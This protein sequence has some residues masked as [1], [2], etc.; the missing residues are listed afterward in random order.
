MTVVDIYCRVSTDEQEDNSS[1]DEQESSGREF[2]RE[3]GLTVGK[4][5]REVFSAYVY[6]ERKDL[7]EMRQRYRG[8]KI[9]GVVIW[10]LDRLSRNQTHTAVLLDEMEYY[11]VKLYC[12][13]EKVDDTPM[14]KFVT[15]ALALIAEM[16]REKII[17]RT[18]IGR[19]NKAK[20][21]KVVSGVKA[22]YGWKWTFKQEGDK[23][24]RDALVLDDDAAE[25]LKKA[26]Q[27]YADGVSLYQT[28]ER[29]ESERVPSP[30]GKKWSVR[31]LRRLL[32]D[33]RMTG[34][35]VKIFV[36]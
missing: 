15:A 20:D 5:H 1:L 28:I 14:G 9:Q 34:K 7:A 10:T 4:V 35:N 6:R 33:P 23:L 19:V 2:C 22:R 25:V 21:G 16:E 17:D 27:E 3:N 12:I 13:K 18:M 30:T 36:V 31:T 29:L 24:V 32:V 26:A 11:K 8:G